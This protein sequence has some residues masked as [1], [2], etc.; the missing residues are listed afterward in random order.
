MLSFATGMVDLC[1]ESG[2]QFVQCFDEPSSV[3]SG[4]Q[5]VMCNLVAMWVVFIPAKV[6]AVF[7]ERVRLTARLV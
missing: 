6:L 4:V 3:S 5:H 2:N 7:I 1:G